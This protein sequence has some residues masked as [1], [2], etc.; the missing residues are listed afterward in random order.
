MPV[1][2]ERQPAYRWG[3]GFDEDE[4]QRGLRALDG[5]P[6]T[7]PGSDEAAASD[8]AWGHHFSS[9]LVAR[10]PPGLPVPAGAF[11]EAQRRIISYEFSDPAIVQAHFDE[12]HSLLGR[13]ML[14][15]LK[16]LGLHLL[17]G[18]LV[19]EVRD[20]QSAQCTVWGFRYETLAGHVEAGAE[21]FLLSKN[22]AT[23]EVHFR[24]EAAWRQG[25]LPNW[26]TRLGFHTLARHYQRAWHR[27]AYARLR[28]F[29]HARDLP[30]LPRSR[31]IIQPFQP[32][33]S[34]PVYERES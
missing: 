18:V 26:W 23:G 17:C 20:E 12:R 33:V 29:V 6:V 3:G 2:S 16:V 9:A 28:K 13:R 25:N 15:E 27:S 11:A 8:P 19:A 34:E 22:H 7:G 32:A 24:I 5:S 1:Y 30:V 21:W 10:E 14:L 31:A 4:L